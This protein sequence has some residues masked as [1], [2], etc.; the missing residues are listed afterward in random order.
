[1]YIRKL[2]NA[3]F[4]LHCIYWTRWYLH[5]SILVAQSLSARLPGKLQTP[6][7]PLTHPDRLILSFWFIFQ[8]PFLTLSL[9]VNPFLPS[10]PSSPCSHHHQTLAPHL[11]TSSPC[12][13][14]SYF[15]YRLCTTLRSAHPG[16]FSHS[17]LSPL[18]LSLS[19]SFFS[20]P[21]PFL[22]LLV[23][24]EDSSSPSLSPHLLTS[25]PPS[26]TGFA[27]LCALLI[28]DYSLVSPDPT[29]QPCTQALAWQ[30]GA[31]KWNVRHLY[32]EHIYVD[33][34]WYT[35][36]LGPS[37]WNDQDLL[38]A[39]SS[40]DRFGLLSIQSAWLEWRTNQ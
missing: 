11:M 28:P 36:R 6:N 31:K 5:L 18:F 40:L 10:P 13:F 16:L 15:C 2:I 21:P 35:P 1:M 29:L 4:A 9:S 22:H 27:L 32:M 37:D 17:T 33:I 12:D 23:L 20:F 3:D 7:R 19:L 14:F 39:W 38:S 26:V 25:S 8:A 34:E 24:T 30:V